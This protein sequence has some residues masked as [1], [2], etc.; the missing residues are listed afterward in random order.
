MGRPCPQDTH[1]NAIVKRVVSKEQT[2]YQTRGTRWNLCVHSRPHPPDSLTRLFR[3]RSWTSDTM[4]STMS[5]MNKVN[6]CM[7]VY[8]KRRHAQCIGTLRLVFI[9]IDS[10]GTGTIRLVYWKSQWQW[11]TS[12]PSFWCFSVRQPQGQC[13]CSTE[14]ARP[15]YLCGW[16]DVLAESCESSIELIGLSKNT[17]ELL[18]FILATFPPY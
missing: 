16:M 5:W 18:R 1:C 17:R 2:D 4:H 14:E 11:Q 12:R 9:Y 10:E 15:C 13:C 7:I 6:L 8:L 3:K